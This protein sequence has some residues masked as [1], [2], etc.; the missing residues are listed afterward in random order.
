MSEFINIFWKYFVAKHFTERFTII[1]RRT[2]R[3][4]PVH[5]NSPVR[6]CISYSKFSWERR[7]VNDQPPFLILYFNNSSWGN[8][9]L[10]SINKIKF[11][12]SG[13]LPNGLKQDQDCFTLAEPQDSMALNKIRCALTKQSKYLKTYFRLA[14]RASI[15][16][17]GSQMG[18]L[19]A[20][21]NYV[22]N[23]KTP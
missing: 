7:V 17:D 1:F 19:S 11:F 6:L 21:Q 5:C 20:F 3:P 9:C 4:V 23:N 14:S 22:S 18:F 13:I 12:V 15:T 10:S 16:A 2:K 8:L